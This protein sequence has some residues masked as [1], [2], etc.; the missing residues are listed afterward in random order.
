MITA[1][2][3]SLPLYP[4]Y[5]QGIP[6]NGIILGAWHRCQMDEYALDFGFMHISASS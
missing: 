1:H 5:L 4:L 6:D 3:K 2:R